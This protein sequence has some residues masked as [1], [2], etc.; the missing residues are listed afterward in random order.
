MIPCLCSNTLVR[1]ITE[2]VL[3]QYPHA[4]PSLSYKAGSTLEDPFLYGV[5]SSSSKPRTFTWRALSENAVG[6]L[7][8]YMNGWPKQMLCSRNFWMKND[9][10]N[11]GYH[12]REL[13]GVFR[14]DGKGFIQMELNRRPCFFRASSSIASYRHL[15]Y[16]HLSRDLACVAAR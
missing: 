4:K 5:L 3:E 14:R 8:G 6:P 13:C 1:W 15:H 11:V 16:D 10:S 12:P 2:P 7:P 9:V